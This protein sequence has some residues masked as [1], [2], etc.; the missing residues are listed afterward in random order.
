MLNFM[1][2]MLSFYVFPTNFP[3]LNTLF[4]LTNFR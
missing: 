4:N 1:T 3:K 2:T